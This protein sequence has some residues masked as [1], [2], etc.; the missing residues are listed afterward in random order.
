LLLAGAELVGV[1]ALQVGAVPAVLQDLDTRSHQRLLVD[2]QHVCRRQAVGLLAAL[3]GLRGPG[4]LGAGGRG[5]RLLLRG[6]LGRR[7]GQ[8]LLDRL[9]GPPALLRWRRRLRLRLRLLRRRLPVRGLA[10]HGRRQASPAHPGC[11]AL[12]VQV[13]D[14]QVGEARALVDWGSRSLLTLFRAPMCTERS[15]GTIPGSRSSRR[16]DVGPI[17][18][19]HKLSRA[20]RSRPILAES[21]QYHEVANLDPNRH[22]PDR[23]AGRARSLWR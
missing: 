18:F 17:P 15:T 13:G 7:R 4:A 23:R 6:G 12:G 19:L 22:Q 11:C 3:G 9:L 10:Q 16:R 1:V 20:R 14:G 2:R 21:F 5:R 8:C